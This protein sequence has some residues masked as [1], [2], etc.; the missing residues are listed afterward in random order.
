MSFPV[1]VSTEICIPSLSLRTKWRVSSY[2]ILLS[3]R[4]LSSFSWA[5]MRYWVLLWLSLRRS[6]FPWGVKGSHYFLIKINFNSNSR[7][8]S[9]IVS[10]SVSNLSTLNDA[11]S[12]PVYGIISWCPIV[13]IQVA[14]DSAIDTSCFWSA[15]RT[16]LIWQFNSSWACLKIT[17]DL[18][19]I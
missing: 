19:E 15:S 14:F 16:C 7:S 13:R 8:T 9:L 3:A 6:L 12:L 2:W 1:K 10:I 17:M 18:K 11:H 4:A 5:G